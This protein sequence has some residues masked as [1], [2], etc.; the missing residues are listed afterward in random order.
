MP[1]LLLCAPQGLGKTLECLSLLSYLKAHRDLPGPHLII[2]PKSTSSNWMREIGRW[3]PNLS[4]AKFHGSQQEREVQKRVL[5][6]Q[7]VTVTTYE[8]VI[9]EKA[10]LRKVPWR[11]LVIDE[12]HRIKNE[13]SLLATVVRTLP[14]Q[15]RLLIT[16]TPLQNSLHELWALLNFLVP[17]MFDAAADFEQW[18]D[19][20]A[21]QTAVARHRVPIL[22]ISC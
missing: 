2:V 20:R 13:H 8:M 10:A 9:R 22:L 15:H 3:T 4:C 18:S 5:G 6:Q 12:A 11:Y 16:G 7:D 17:T 19:T 14:S 21:A 1:A